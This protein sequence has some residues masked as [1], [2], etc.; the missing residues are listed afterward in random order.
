MSE[1]KWYN[2]LVT[3]TLR[4]RLH[5]MMSASTVLVTV[6]GRKSGRPYTLPISYHQSGDTLTI[7]T[8]RDK[9]WWRNV[10]DGAPVRL[11]LRGQEVEGQAQVVDMDEAGMLAAVREVWPM[12]GTKQ[13]EEAASASVLV[14]IRLAPEDSP[15]QK[16]VQHA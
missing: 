1:K 8:R 10:R 13:A 2:P 12:I 11:L 16:V 6:T 7:I 9:S 3:W 4:S 14:R 15:E 5:G